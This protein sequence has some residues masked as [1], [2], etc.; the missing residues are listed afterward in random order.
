MHAEQTNKLQHRTLPAILFFVGA[1][2]VFE[3]NM[4]AAV[5]LACGLLFRFPAGS[6]HSLA[7][8]RRW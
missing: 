3:P 8:Q 4:M 1:S 2:S 5:S 6:Q 7:K